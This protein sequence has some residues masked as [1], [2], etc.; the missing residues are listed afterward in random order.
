[1]ALSLPAQVSSLE[2]VARAL[3]PVPRRTV[4][5]ASNA[6]GNHLDLAGAQRRWR[7]TAT[8]VNEYEIV[9]SGGRENHKMPHV[10]IRMHSTTRSMG[11]EGSGE[12]SRLQTV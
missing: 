8:E 3:Y 5:S 7:P 9:G 1:M 4:P 6:F 12:G 10:T 11:G 2:R